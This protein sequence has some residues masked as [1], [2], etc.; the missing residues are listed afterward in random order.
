MASGEGV[1][2]G[3]VYATNVAVVDTVK[4]QAINELHQMGVSTVVPLGVPDALQLPFAAQQMLTK[5]L[6]DSV[7]AI[8]ILTDKVSLL[9]VG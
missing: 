3:I 1:R 5:G 6:V 7:I 4:Q 9:V 8:A 2:V